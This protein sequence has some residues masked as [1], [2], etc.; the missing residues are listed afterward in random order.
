[1]GA[2]RDLEAAGGVPRRRCIAWALVATALAGP[3]AAP[4]AAVTW[5]QAARQRPG[6][7]Q[8]DE[9]RRVVA[10]VI[11]YQLPCGGW[12][13]NIDMAA[14][15][16]DAARAALAERT[17]EGTI[18]NGAT[19]EQLRFLA[20]AI[21]AA[22]DADKAPAAAASF[23]RGIDYLLEAQ[24]DNGGWPMYYPLRPRGYYSHIHFNDDGMANVLNLLADIAEGRPGFDFVDAAGRQRAAAALAR[25]IE[26]ILKC[27]V[28]VDGQRTAWCAQHDEHTL[29]PAK[30]RTYELPSLSGQESVAVVRVLMR[31]QEPTPEIIAAVNDAVA[32]LERVKITGQRI[33]WV[34]NEDGVDRIVVDDPQASP[35]W[36]R[37]YEIGTNRP[38]FVGR[39]G[40]V[41]DRLADIERERRVHYAYLGAWPAELLAEDYP[42]W[43]QRIDPPR[44]SDEPAIGAQ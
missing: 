14:R 35:L 6:W 27:Q 15:L 33:E 34:R 24:Y 10:N 40:V 2:A 41:R 43:R 22:G 36:A 23:Q 3:L 12:D 16:D 44:P 32:W 17:D 5:R 11:A 31:I 20:R 39:D 8:S 25:G 42:A 30:A 29:A 21:A 28:V 1:M 7:F 9:G 18:D 4:V 19:V 37:F 13:K 38:M 26:C